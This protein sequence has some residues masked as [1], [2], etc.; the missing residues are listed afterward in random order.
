MIASVLVVGLLPHDAGKTTVSEALLREALA[1]G[2]EPSAFK[3]VSAFSG[4]YQFEYL[5]ESVELG[6]LVGEDACRLHRASRS[7]RPIEMEAPVVTLLVPPD[8]SALEWRLSLYERAVESVALQAVLTRVTA[9]RRGLPSTS[10]FLVEQ[11]LRRTTPALRRHVEKLVERVRVE[12]HRIAPEE[13]A[14]LLE[15]QAAQAADECL[16][17]AR[18]EGELLVVES[19]NNALAP[20]RGS[21]N[22]TAVV[23]VAPGRVAVYSGSEYVRAAQAVGAIEFPWRSTTE[24]VVTLL[25]PSASLE[26]EPM[27]RVGE[28]ERATWAERLLDAILMVS[29]REVE[30]GTQL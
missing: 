13:L 22:V 18:L 1:R 17:W 28:L 15:G 7:K 4:W 29:E 30:A 10:Y 11:A 12:P 25:R 19:Y 3:P 21:L 27:R 9:C 14:S 24:R 8:P 16:E 5:L 23:L 2:L 6:A 26:V 20:T